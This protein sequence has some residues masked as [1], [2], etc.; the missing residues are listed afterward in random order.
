LHTKYQ[1]RNNM[2]QDKLLVT[3][4]EAPLETTEFSGNISRVTLNGQEL[5]AKKHKTP[6]Y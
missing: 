4:T 3:L 2:N 1:R 6:G 5:L